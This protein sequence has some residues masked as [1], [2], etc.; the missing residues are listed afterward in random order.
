M[1]SIPIILKP[2]HITENPIIFP[3]LVC[4][5]INLNG[6]DD[7]QNFKTIAGLLKKIYTKE[8]KG[9][10]IFIAWTSHKDKLKAL[11]RH[12]EADQE[13]HKPLDFIA[14][15]KDEYTD[16]PQKLERKI[17]YIFRKNKGLTACLLWNNIIKEANDETI[18]SLSNLAEKTNV[19]L[20]ALL[21][22]LAQANLGKKKL[23]DEATATIRPIN[24][25]L[26]DNI[27][28]KL[29]CSPAQTKL[30][31]ILKKNP[32]NLALSESG[33]SNTNF[34][35]HISPNI[36]YK[37]IMPGD[38]MR[39]YEKDLK[40]IF[41][42]VPEELKSNLIKRGEDTN[43]IELGLLEITPDCDY[44]N[45]K[46]HDVN[47]FALTYLIPSGISGKL[48]N[49]Y[50]KRTKIKIT[51]N[52]AE[53]IF[54]VDCRYIISIIPKRNFV[55]NRIFSLKENLFTSF[56]QQVYAY[57]SRIGTISF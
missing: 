50:Y 48:D 7:T 31:N 52:E 32:K 8:R 1:G 5:D 55:K 15:G 24:Y 27:E 42:K 25:I 30:N 18:I 38:V 40:S 44:T 33:K 14:I 35:L 13:I 37:K 39:I 23:R 11:R 56:R 12:I 6:T 49:D 51:Y 26:R 16:N 36:N 21:D 54:V 34:I 4:C 19:D 9:I 3:K 29:I 45:V 20:L 28:K 2:E 43:N 17:D 22:G 53:Y 47:K 46:T 57:N 41:R 10:Y